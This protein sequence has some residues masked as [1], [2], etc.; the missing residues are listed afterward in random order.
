MDDNNALAVSV[1][2]AAK[3]LGVGTAFMWALIADGR[4]P[5]WRLGKRRLISSRALEEFVR[6]RE[7]EPEQVTSR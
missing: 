4:V 3:R 1:P 6:Q 7:A 5:S 2:T